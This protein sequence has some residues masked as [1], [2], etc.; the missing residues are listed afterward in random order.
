MS[1]PETCHSESKGKEIRKCNI[2]V[3]VFLII[4]P[5]YIAEYTLLNMAVWFNVFTGLHHHDSCRCPGTRY[6]TGHQQSQTMLT[7]LGD[8]ASAIDADSTLWQAKS[9]H[10]TDSTGWQGISNRHTDSTRWQGISNHYAESRWQAISN[11]HANS[12][13]M[14]HIMQQRGHDPICFSVLGIH[15]FRVV[16]HYGM[17]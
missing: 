1:D 16:T 7:Q 4:L 15:L 11:H 9:N 2:I 8:R 3:L 13:G 12:T 6:M 14:N 5:S 17:V 10:H